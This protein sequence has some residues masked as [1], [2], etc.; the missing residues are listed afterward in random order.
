MAVRDPDEDIGG[1][2]LLAVVA[3][4][5]LAAGLFLGVMSSLDSDDPGDAPLVAAC[6]VGGGLLGLVGAVAG[7]ALGR[8]LLVG[9]G[10]LLVGSAVDGFVASLSWGQGLLELVLFGSMTVL[11]V[12]SLVVAFRSMVVRRRKRQIVDSVARP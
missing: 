11:G 8:W 12:A 7:R 2:A 5:V 9:F 4:L 10:A 3:V 6:L 1:R